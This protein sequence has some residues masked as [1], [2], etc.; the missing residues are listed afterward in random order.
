MWSKSWAALRG[1]LVRACPWLA[2]WRAKMYL[3]FA[4]LI[5]MAVL[6]FLNI[7]VFRALWWSMTWGVL[8]LP[9]GWCAGRL[10][11]ESSKQRTREQAEAEARRKDAI[12]N[13]LWRR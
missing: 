3:S 8:T 5:V 2:T 7:Y 4:I 12:I 9:V 11:A 6:P 13:H 10:I 1:A